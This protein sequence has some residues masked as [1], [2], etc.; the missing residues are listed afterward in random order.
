MVEG[1]GGCEEWGLQDLTVPSED[2]DM[3]DVF[4]RMESTIIDSQPACLVIVA[5]QDL[6]DP[7]HIRLYTLSKLCRLP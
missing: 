4:F 3:T 5:Q 6:V 7:V 1:S 2:A